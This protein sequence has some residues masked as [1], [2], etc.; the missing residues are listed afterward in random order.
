MQDEANK[1]GLYTGKTKAE[2]EAIAS[3]MRAAAKSFKQIAEEEEDEDEEE[4][5]LPARKG[6][7]AVGGR[8][9]K[10]GAAER[11][12][13]ARRTAAEREKKSA[14]A[15]RAQRRVQVT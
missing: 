7:P 10:R 8:R 9:S 6:S 4:L 1:T 14:A 5:E 13:S 3:L 15:V 12:E 11:G 2:R